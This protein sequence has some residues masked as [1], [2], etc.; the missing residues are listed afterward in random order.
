[1]AVFEKNGVR[2]L[3]IGGYAVAF[4]AEP[5]FT[6][7]CDIWIATDK[8]NAE[9]VYKSLVEFQAPLHG[10]TAEDFEDDDAFFFFGNAPNRV[11]ILMGPPGGDFEASWPRRL[12][13]TV[14]GV[15]I[16]YASRDDLIS[17]KKA[18]GRPVDKRDIKALKASAPEKKPKKK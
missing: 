14:Q 2:Y 16:Y 9:A 13:T 10:V 12:A 15:T 7:D 17:L 1:L 5:R 8:K 18:A 6:K 4:H 11:D 3:I